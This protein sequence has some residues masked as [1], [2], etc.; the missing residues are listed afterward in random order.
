MQA[1]RTASAANAKR[2]AF[3]MTYTI[4]KTTTYAGR[5][6]HFSRGGLRSLIV[7]ARR[8]IDSLFVASLGTDRADT[9]RRFRNSASCAMTE[10]VKRYC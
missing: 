5:T 2:K 1:T 9:L 7:P 8:G 4:Q 6:I 10:H 3:I